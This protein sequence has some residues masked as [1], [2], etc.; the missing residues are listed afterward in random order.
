M[1]SLIILTLIT[2]SF[3]IKAGTVMTG[4]STINSRTEWFIPLSPTNSDGNRKVVG[5]IKDSS[6]FFM[7]M[8]TIKFT[9]MAGSGTRITMFNTDGSLYA[10]DKWT[11]IDTGSTLVSKPWLNSIVANYMTKH[12]A[13]S[14]INI[15]Q[16]DIS[17]KAPQSMNLTINGV[18][19][20]LSANRNW[21]VGTLTSESDPYWHSDSG[22]YYK[23]L[24]VDDLFQ[25]KLGYTPYNSTN[26][27]GYIS[28]VPAQ[29]FSSLTGKPTSLSGYGITDAYP[30]SGNPSSFLTSISGAQVN[31][32]LGYTAYDA[33]TNS[34]NFVN[35]STLT[36]G[37]ATKQGA[38]TLSNT[39]TS[40]AATLVG[41]T[42]NIPVYA[43]S[44]G[45]V[46]SVTSADATTA[47]VAT[48]TTTPVISIVSAP[49]LKTARNINGVSFDGTGDITINAAPTI[50][51]PASGISITPGTAFQ[52]RSG[53]ACYILVNASITGA[54]GLN[55]TITVAL[56][57]T[58]GG[59]YTTVA[60]DVLLIGLLG[61]T[62]DRSVASIPVPSGYWV[63]VTRSGTAASA[64]Y[65]RFD[66]N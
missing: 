12:F 61:L 51:A 43:N 3:Y 53:G 57:S 6:E 7:D 11:L 13:D 32:A 16:T 8:A 18:T 22:N 54:L 47:T 41:N 59:T 58:S 24:R 39:G 2:L 23:K 42:L 17:S 60:T 31:S 55:E 34:S 63:K 33:T 27:A 37:L 49:K 50:S 19:Q 4:N 64:T 44:G 9:K 29:S 21:S 20:N 38:L 25:T 40:G 14:M 28:S 62:L 65:T 5:W 56:S 45:T 36:S 1:K 26:P 35:I 48:S 66:L 30:L 10:M 52:P 46:T 15:M